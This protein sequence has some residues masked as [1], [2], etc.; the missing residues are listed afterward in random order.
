MNL[1]KI[2]KEA[3]AAMRAGKFDQTSEAGVISMFGGGLLAWGEYV[4]GVNGR[5]FRRH[6]N[7]LV[8]QGIRYFLNV[9]LGPTTTKISAWFLAPFT[10]ST[11]PAAN[12]TAANFTSNSTEN[13]STSEGFSE[14]TRQAATF[15]EPTAVDQ[16]DN[17]AAKAAFTIVTA[18][19][20]T[21]TGMGLLSSS[22][23]GGTSGV[24]I[25]ATKFGTARVLQNADVWNVGYRLA[26]AST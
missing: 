15:V 3:R 8:D 6:K 12:W 26:L 11:S 25:S 2:V 20:L 19:S 1:Q 21:I 17:Y 4:E 7:L 10:G 22:T 5:D 23:R 13:T 14:S 18:T 24:L 9:G 16:I